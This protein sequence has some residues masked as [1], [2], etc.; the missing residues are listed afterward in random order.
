MEW[1][2]GKTGQ[3]GPSFD[4]SKG[5]AERISQTERFDVVENR[6]EGRALPIRMINSWE[7]GRSSPETDK[8]VLSADPKDHNGDL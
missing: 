7:D 4:T 8:R 6:G 5:E 2:A 1:L 3:T